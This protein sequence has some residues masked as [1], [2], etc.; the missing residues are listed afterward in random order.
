MDDFPP[1]PAILM[2]RGL[3][4][5]R[6]A[7]S[8]VYD[9]GA[10]FSSIPQMIDLSSEQITEMSRTNPEEFARRYLAKNIVKCSFAFEIYKTRFQSVRRVVDLG[11]GPGTFMFAISASSPNTNEFVG[12]DKSRASLKVAAS[13]FRNSH[14]PQPLF[15]R[16]PVPQGVV[17]GG[18]FFTASYL[19]AEMGDRNYRL[20]LDWIAL[21]ADARFLL[22]DYP[23]KVRDVSRRLAGHRPCQTRMVKLQLPRDIAEI[24][25]DDQIS[26]GAAYVPITK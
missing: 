26:F 9:N 18:K 7:L 11:T 20:F 10:R 1:L 12:V 14:L 21:R 6:Q 4:R 24:V 15:I 8:N 17:A 5:A 23:H 19:V 25:G 22:V 13:I 2:R 3:E 16:A